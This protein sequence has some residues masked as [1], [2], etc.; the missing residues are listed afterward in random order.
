[1]KQAARQLH[2]TYYQP[3]HAHASIGPSCAVADAGRIKSQSGPAPRTLSPTRRAGPVARRSEEK[4]RLIH[5]EGAG[6]YGQNGSD[7]ATADAAFLSQAVRPWPVRLQWTREQEFIWEPKA[8]AM[9]MEIHAGLDAQGNVAAWDYH[10]WSP[11]HVCGPRMAKQLI[12]AQL[13]SG[14]AAI[15]SPLLL[16]RRA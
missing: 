13:L 4:V 9:V 10:A 14:Q 15:P 1:M 6:S 8:P 12:T 11:T 3:F 7:D 16:W 5:V 2:A